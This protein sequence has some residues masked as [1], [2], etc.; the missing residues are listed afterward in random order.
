MLIYDVFISLNSSWNQFSHINTISI[1]K[2][3]EEV[4]QSHVFWP[5]VFDIDFRKRLLLWEK[6]FHHK[7]CNYQCTGLIAIACIKTCYASCTTI[8]W[9]Q[10]RNFLM[11]QAKNSKLTHF[12]GTEFNLL[13]LKVF[14]FSEW[15][16]LY[17]W[18]SLLQSEHQLF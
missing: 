15:T 6:L 14:L 10:S 18:Y 12:Q 4:K 7:Y 3:M 16:L 11:V 2:Y 9:G 8:V 13:W 17:R 5:M 1:L